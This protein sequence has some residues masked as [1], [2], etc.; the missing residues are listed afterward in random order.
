MNINV[1][2]FPYNASGDGKAD[3]REAIQR[4]IDFVHKNGGG[5]VKLDAGKTFKVTSIVIRSGVTLHFEDGAVLQQAAGSEGYYKPAGEKYEKYVPSPGHNFSGEIKWSHNWYRNYPFIFAPEGS[6][7]FA[8]TGN[9]TLRMCEVEDPETLIKICPIGFYRC[10]NFTIS[11]ITITNYHSYAMMP[12]TSSDGLIKNVKI[13]NWSHGNGDGICLMNCKNIRITGCEMFTGDD[14][15]YIFSSYRD[16]RRSEWWNSDEPQA[17]ENIEIDH[18]DLKSNHCKAFGMILWGIECDD[19]EKVEVR[20]VYVHDNHIETLGNWL[21]NPYSQKGGFPPVTN[22]RF[23]NNVIDGIEANFFDTHISDMNYFRSMSSIQNGNFEN[24]RCFWSMKTSA[25]GK[26]GVHREENNSY[27]FIETADG[28]NAALYQGLYIEAGKPC[29]FKAEVMSDGGSFNLFVRNLVSGNLIASLPF[30]SGQWEE[31]FLD[32]TVGESGNYH[33]GIESGENSCGC[34][35]IRN[36]ALGYS[37]NAA[38]DYEVIYDRG[39]MIYKYN[40][41]LF[42]R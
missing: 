21:W 35:K 16:P 11:D 22:V 14:S 24:G 25:G 36:A 32:F 41:N 9:G 33:I 29:L 10:S 8:V 42:R 37:E 40:E 1:C 20:N 27:G 31:K 26:A 30:H 15:V 5:T 23:E 12:F 38:G 34:A 7:D 28:G 17:S 3:D 6:T 2:S 18:N 13:N 4:A 39:K 19:L